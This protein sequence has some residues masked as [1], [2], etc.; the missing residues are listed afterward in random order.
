MKRPR[1]QLAPAV[2]MQ[3]GVD[4]A[5]A[6]RMPDRFLVGRLEIMDVKDL[7]GTGRFGKTREQSL[8]FGQRHVLVLAS[9]IRLRFERPDAAVVIGH[10]RAVYRA[11]RHAHRSRNRRLRH[12][13]LTQQHHLDA[14][15][16]RRRYLP[17]QRSFQPPHLAFAA[18]GHLFFSNQMVQA[19]HTLGEENSFPTSRSPYLRQ[20]SIQAVMEVVLVYRPLAGSMS[21]TFTQPKAVRELASERTND[22]TDIF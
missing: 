10:V 18:F 1:H 6:G 15:A 21:L 17:S 19:N 12:P 22:Q 4:R 3:E 13:A 2:P 14:L 16:L 7:A 8:F 20:I 9:T 11:Q 5:V